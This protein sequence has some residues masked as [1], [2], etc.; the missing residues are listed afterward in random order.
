[1]TSQLVQ[2]LEQFWA[3]HYRFFWVFTSYCFVRN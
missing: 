3:I 2:Q 1:M